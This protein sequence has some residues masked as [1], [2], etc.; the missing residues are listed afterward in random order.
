MSE[1][2][3]EMDE[4]TPA[5]P[6][7]FQPTIR[8]MCPNCSI[9]LEVSS[10]VGLTLSSCVLK[11]TDTT[12]QTLYLRAVPTAGSNSRVLSLKFRTVVS[13]ND[14]VWQGY[15]VPDITVTIQ[16]LSADLSGVTRISV[17]EGHGRGLAVFYRIL[18]FGGL[19]CPFKPGFH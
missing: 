14:S 5:V 10:H 3:I 2:F 4:S 11:F 12:V 9:R 16:F 15:R 1:Y 8:P 19:C 13:A 6:L 7:V 18:G 17:E